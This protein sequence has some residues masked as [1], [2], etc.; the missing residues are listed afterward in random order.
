MVDAGIHRRLKKLLL[1]KIVEELCLKYLVI[2][3]DLQKLSKKLSSEQLEILISEV[4]EDVG[5][6]EQNN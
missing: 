1:K 5:K 3:P 6:L 2:Y 4:V